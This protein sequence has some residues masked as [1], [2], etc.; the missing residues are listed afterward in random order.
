[1]EGGENIKSPTL[2]IL[3]VS[4]LLVIHME[5]LCGQVEKRESGRFG[6]V[7]A[8]GLWEL[9]ACRRLLRQ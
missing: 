8:E 2:A 3:S 7:R 4:C 5:M 6:K 9:L 1:M